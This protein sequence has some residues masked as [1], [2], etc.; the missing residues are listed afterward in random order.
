MNSQPAVLNQKR[1]KPEPT[2]LKP[3]KGAPK[4]GIQQKEEKKG[5]TPNDDEDEDVTKNE[6]DSKMKEENDE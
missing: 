2:L 1:A 5:I 3:S 6:E 4:F